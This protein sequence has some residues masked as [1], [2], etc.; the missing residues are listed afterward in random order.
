MFI[1][2]GRTGSLWEE[3]SRH[4]SLNVAIRAMRRESRRGCKP[5]YPSWPARVLKVEVIL[6]FTE[7]KK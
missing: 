3:I 1:V 4:K 7:T 5:S 6:N 2:E